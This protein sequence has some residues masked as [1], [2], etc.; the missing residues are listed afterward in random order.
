[1]GYPIYLIFDSHKLSIFGNAFAKLQ[2]IQQFDVPDLAN[3]IGA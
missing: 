2:P 3:C 1:M